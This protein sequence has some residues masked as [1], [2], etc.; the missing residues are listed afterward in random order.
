MQT[1]CRMALTLMLLAGVAHAD[2]LV[3]GD[4][5]AITL[6]IGPDGRASYKQDYHQDLATGEQRVFAV[7]GK[8]MWRDKPWLDL[9]FS[10]SRVIYKLEL[11]KPVATLTLGFSF[12]G[13][14]STEG[15]VAVSTD[16]QQWTPLWAYDPAK[17]PV[18]AHVSGSADLASYLPK[19]PRP[20]LYLKFGTDTKWG[21][22]FSWSL[23]AFE[24]APPSPRPYQPGPVP[25]NG[26][27]RYCIQYGDLDTD[28]EYFLQQS[29]VN[30]FH[31]HGPFSGYGG[32]VERAKLESQKRYAQETIARAHASGMACLLYIGPCFSYGDPEKRTQ[33][34]G[35]YDNLWPQYED[36]FGPRPGDVLDQTQRDVQGRPRPYEYGGQQGYH[37]CVNSPGVRQMTKGLIRM[38]IES[39]G[40]GSFYDGPYVT[41]GRC[42]CRWCRDKFR[43][44]LKD[45]V[46]PADLKAHCGVT[47][48]ATVEPPQSASEKLWVPFR[49]FNAWSLLDF[50]QDTKAY[51]RKLNPH[52]IMTSNYC[53]WSGEPFSPIRGTAEDA[54]LEGQVVDVLFD[55]AKYGAGPRLE[56]SGKVSNSTD[57]RHLL[58]AAQGIPVA[59]LKTA[60]EGTNSEAGGNLTRLA[61]AEAAANGGAWQLHRLKP[62]A[63]V[64]A[65]QYC[66]FLADRESVM[67]R[68]KPWVTVGI[69]TSSTQAYFDLPTY[70]TA[71]SRYLA[72]NHLPHRL[73]IDREV[74][75]GKLDGLDVLIVPRVSVISDKQ[76]AVLE[77]F[78]RGGKGLILVNRCGEK[79][80]WGEAREKLPLGQPT[81]EHI[82]LPLKT[83]LGRGRIAYT[84]CPPLPQSPNGGLAKE[85][86]ARLHVEP[87]LIA[88]ASGH[89]LPAWIAATDQVE[90]TT[91]YDGKQTLL[92]SLV[93][94]GVELSGHLQRCGEMPLRVML[95]PGTTVQSATLVSPDTPVG[96]KGTPLPCVTLAPGSQRYARVVLPGLDIFSQVQFA[97]K[98]AAA[99]KAGPLQLEVNG[100][101]VPGAQIG[102]SVFGAAGAKT[103]LA[104]P[105]GWKVVKTAAVENGTANLLS[106][107]K[108]DKSALQRVGVT[109]RLPGGVVLTDEAWL[110]LRR[111]LELSLHM[112]PYADTH[113]GRS[114][115]TIAVRNVLDESATVGIR[116][117][118]PPGWS[119]D[120]DS[121]AETIEGQT[122]AGLGAWLQAPPD[123][124]PG[125]YTISAVAT[126]GGD[127]VRAETSFSVVDHLQALAC[128]Y[129]PQ[130]QGVPPV[131][132]A[133]KID[134]KLD[135]PCWKT[136]AS[137][138]DFRRNDDKGPAHQ[139]TTARVCHDDR[140]LY[141]AFECQESEPQT[142]V[143]LVADD[144]G[145][146]WR[147][148]SVE[149]FLDAG[150]TGRNVW[151]WIASS[152]GK[153]TPA[154][155]WEVA[156][157]RTATGWTAEMAL[158]ISGVRHQ[159]GDM[160]GI[161]LCRTRPSRPQQEPEFS[162]WARL[163]GG[164]AQPDK[165]G[166]L[167]FGE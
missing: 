105:T 165:F 67:V 55:E 62:A 8:T 106:I 10:A 114:A 107:P 53:M 130:A 23:N 42:Y 28:L 7:E 140:F 142:I 31:W 46:S 157:Q 1:T 54:E 17:M 161:N 52:Y 90:V 148:D 96:A 34:F 87:E 37:L 151:H 3:V 21:L 104:L 43:Q 24:K 77:A 110:P 19:T 117:I 97:L 138:T 129:I 30:V 103:E 126:A 59:L 159:P 14:E 25:P 86:V 63:Q 127:E 118:A 36:Y 44:W 80:E 4:G 69:W 91:A 38:I 75:S 61:L 72:D 88:W 78:A 35:F 111:P 48:T 45:N 147:D 143:N 131:G 65:E 116:L 92:A 5:S 112:P 74:E 12:W 32:F 152:A 71:L 160:W 6:A 164:F 85:D 66:A 33:L 2:K 11:S 99:V 47:D 167:I 122:H 128:R 158:P 108:T 100:E 94:Y 79:D 84:T 150:M 125:V 50:M 98:P 13:T 89:G 20:V 119:F 156:T 121:I 134:G 95:P 29:R 149:V 58:A 51:A 15:L 57:Y 83:Q 27:L 81:D 82:M 18:G 115:V 133:A 155:G 41:E 64:G 16:G 132:N 145:E 166:V 49:R 93:N 60:P 26:A 70:P 76:L 9:A 136:A 141:V 73:V 163:T 120:K 144:G 68:C 123:A 137:V 102:L 139:Q 39:G 22:L 56:A 153:K 154:Q 113:S 146:V 162:S 101:P 135:E 124:R 109:V 40:D